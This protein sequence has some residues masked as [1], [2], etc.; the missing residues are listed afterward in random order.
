MRS[1]NRSQ[2][3]MEYHYWWGIVLVIAEFRHW[4]MKGRRSE[5]LTWFLYISSLCVLALVWGINSDSIP[6]N[7]TNTFLVIVNDLHQNIFSYYGSW[8]L[9]I[10]TSSVLLLRTD[11]RS[12]I[13]L[14]VAFLFS[15]SSYVFSKWIFERY[16]GLEQSPVTLA[17][18]LFETTIVFLYAVGPS[19]IL[20]SV[21]FVLRRLSN[22]AKPI[23]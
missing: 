23:S 5:V 17:G 2:I 3:A 6:S 21:Y 11:Q 4:N 16:F 7:E 1:S 9:V 15:L 10:I 8:V 18:I 19:L 20:C 14:V 22:R 13:S 12:I